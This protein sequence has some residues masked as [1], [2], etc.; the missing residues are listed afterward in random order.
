[1]C[2]C[3]PALQVLRN[4]SLAA[5]DT[6]RSVPLMQLQLGA[7]FAPARSATSSKFSVSIRHG[8]NMGST[9]NVTFGQQGPNFGTTW[10]HLASRLAPTWAQIG[11]YMRN[12]R[13]SWD[14]FRQVRAQDG[15]NPDS[16]RYTEDFNFYRYFQ[17]FLALMGV[18]RRPLCPGLSWAQLPRWTP[19]VG[20]KL[21]RARR[22]LGPGWLVFGPT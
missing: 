18:R 14:P 9:W 21:A 22:E 16:M 12:L 1:M 11:S 15:P 4:G 13:P 17:R 6:N 10:T 20:L 19:A 3:V 7:I 2:V 5:R 8:R